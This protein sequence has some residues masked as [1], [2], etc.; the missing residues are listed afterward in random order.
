[1][2]FDDVSKKFL[3]NN[4]H[5]RNSLEFKTPPETQLQ[6]G[7]QTRIGKENTAWVVL[8]AWMVPQPLIIQQNYIRE[9]CYLFCLSL[10][11]TNVSLIWK[12][13]DVDTLPLRQPL[14]ND[15][16]LFI[17]WISG[18]RWSATHQL[19]V[20]VWFG[21][22]TMATAKLGGWFF[23]G[24]IT[25]GSTTDLRVFSCTYPEVLGFR[26]YRNHDKE[27]LDTKFLPV[28]GNDS[29]TILTTA[30]VVR[31]LITGACFLPTWYSSEQVAI[32]PKGTKTNPEFSNLAQHFPELY[33][34][35][36]GT[37][38]HFS[39]ASSK[40]SLTF[41]WSMLEC[42]FLPTQEKLRRKNGHSAMYRLLPA[43]CNRVVGISRN[44][45]HW[46][47]R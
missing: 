29:P 10:L 6:V 28:V 33:C 12:S 22:M 25:Y 47:R 38:V 45:Q 24:M 27:L 4:S 9:T 23:S 16:Q 36:L 37:C 41:F 20:A 46:V 14:F 19:L 15:E 18:P 39:H 40:R 43:N 21:S 30:F 44:G 13:S 3:F 26:V 34:C 31:G 35:C 7:K 42:R 11:K 8:L 5:P 2:I 32:G 1:M 17:V